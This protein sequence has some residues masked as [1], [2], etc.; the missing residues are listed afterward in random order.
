MLQNQVSQLAILPIGSIIPFSVG[1]E[2][3]EGFI[4]FDGRDI[5]R[6]EYPDVVDAILDV[7][8]SRIVIIRPWWEHHGGGVTQTGVRLPD[9]APEDVYKA[10]WQDLYPFRP[11]SPKL[12]LIMKVENVTSR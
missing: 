5:N 8:D 1:D 4:P 7:L 2:I 12:R 9:I 10:V 3:P 6:D 11:D